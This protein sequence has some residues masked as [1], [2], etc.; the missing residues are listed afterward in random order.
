MMERNLERIINQTSFKSVVV[1][2]DE[3]DR[4]VLDK[5]T[6]EN[7]QE[8]NQNAQN[9]VCECE[10]VHEDTNMKKNEQMDMSECKLI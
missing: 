1:N 5:M 2:G 9:E 7:E 8:K 3:S 6:D 10:C 4:S